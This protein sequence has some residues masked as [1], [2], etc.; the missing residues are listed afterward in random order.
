MFRRIVGY[1]FI[2]FLLASC[3][4]FSPTNATSNNKLQEI[5]TI[6]DYTKI[7]VYPIFYDC[8]DFSE[9]NDQKGC[10][11]ASLSKR[12]SELLNKN[13]LK[14]KKAVNDTTHIKLFIDNAGKAKI[15]DINSPGVISQYLPSLDSVIRQIVVKLPK[16]K[17]A[18]KRGVF[19]KSQYKL[20]V[21]IK[22][23]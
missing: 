1:L 4:Y 3:E 21:I 20:S 15:L 22:T 17:P 9:E 5:D 13:S 19:V 7:D 16:V 12:L 8:E 14:V 18:V 11:E 23:I 2:L 6:I 10:F